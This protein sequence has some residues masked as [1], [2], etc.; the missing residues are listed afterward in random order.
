LGEIQTMDPGEMTVYS[1]IL[2]EYIFIN[3]SIAWFILG[4]MS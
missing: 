2:N 4:I 1:L 3:L